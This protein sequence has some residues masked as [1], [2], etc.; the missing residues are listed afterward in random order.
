MPWKSLPESLAAAGLSMTGY[1]QIPFPG[2]VIEDSSHGKR[3]KRSESA[4]QSDNKQ[5]IKQIGTHNARIL[6]QAFK[7]EKIKLVSADK[8]GMNLF[9]SIPALY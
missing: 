4:K 5:G 9:P 2:E 6:L 8:A 3:K 1:P 7:N